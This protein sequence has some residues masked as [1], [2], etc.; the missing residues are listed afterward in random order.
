MADY[1]YPLQGL[2]ALAQG[3]LAGRQ[4]K[5][6]REQREQEFAL[7]QQQ[8]EAQAAREDRIAKAQEMQNQI[9]AMSHLG[10]GVQE[11]YYSPEA[12]DQLN[13]QF[14]PS[15]YPDIVTQKSVSETL[16]VQE[17]AVS[18]PP[19]Q[20][21]RTVEQDNAL[22]RIQV[23]QDYELNRLPNM[24][25]SDAERENMTEG[26]RA[27]MGQLWNTAFGAPQETTIPGVRGAVA[28]EGANIQPRG[29]IFN[30]PLQI[31][32]AGTVEQRTPAPNLFQAPKVK[33]EKPA[34]DPFKDTR[35]E[36]HRSARGG[37]L[38]HADYKKYTDAESA[39]LSTGDKAAFQRA[40]AGI[41][42]REKPE[43]KSAAGDRTSNALLNTY[44]DGISSAQRANATKEDDKRAE[45]KI[46]AE[47]RDK[48][49]KLESS[50]ASGFIDQNDPSAKAAYDKKLDELKKN[51]AMQD[52]KVTGIQRDIVKNLEEANRYR[53]SYNKVLE[54]AGLP[55]TLDTGETPEAEVPE[56]LSQATNEQLLKILSGQ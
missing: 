3:F 10:R 30:R 27:E 32:P 45:E 35:A 44:L 12:A 19:M 49:S 26:I 24:P 47:L 17:L 25:I 4:A 6:E 11:G 18:R 8:M 56:D 53:Q 22:K 55:G 5:Q 39:Y 40:L 31:R 36:Y 42:F 33:P 28:R 29:G 1:S 34:E 50:L 54:Q 41:Q 16:P 52:K 13:R 51:I 21:P 14:S 46:L 20:L 43:S 9:A 38:S 37:L 7:R 2:G 23:L 15:L 48:K